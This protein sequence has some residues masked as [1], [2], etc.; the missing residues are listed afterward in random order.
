VEPFG[1]AEKV[2]GVRVRGFIKGPEVL[3]EGFVEKVTGWV[4]KEFCEEDATEEFFKE[5]FGVTRGRKK[6][7]GRI[8]V[9]RFG[10]EIVSDAKVKLKESVKEV[11][12]EKAAVRRFAESGFVKDVGTKEV[13]VKGG[14][15]REAVMQGVDFKDE[16]V[17]GVKC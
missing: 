11:G 7:C 12:L 16:F 10:E 4:V 2:V 15:L 13:E 17:V 9:R 5:G 6:V 14:D 8:G 3:A 1:V